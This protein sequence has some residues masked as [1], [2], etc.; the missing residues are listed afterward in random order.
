MVNSP[1]NPH[2]AIRD[3]AFDLL[4]IPAMSAEV[5][6]KFSSGR[7]LITFDRNRLSEETIEKRELLKDWWSNNMVAQRVL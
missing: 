1:S 6:R 4:S 2:L 3:L 5:E 7:R